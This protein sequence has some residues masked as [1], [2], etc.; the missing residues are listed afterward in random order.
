MDKLGLRIAGLSPP[1]SS[2]SRIEAIEER[3]SVCERTKVTEERA[4]DIAHMCV[5]GSRAAQDDF[6]NEQSEK[7]K[8]VVGDIELLAK[9]L[10]AIRREGKAEI[11]ERV[12]EATTDISARI[13]RGASSEAATRAHQVGELGESVKIVASRVDGIQDTVASLGFRV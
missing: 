4:V 8:K 6:D 1:G 9:K 11:G 10:D 5:T 12:K 2:N 13:I 7:L 3:I